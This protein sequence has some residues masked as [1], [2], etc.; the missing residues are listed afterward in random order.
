LSTQYKTTKDREKNIDQT[1]GLIEKYFAKKEPSV[2][3]H[4]VGLALD[5]ENS[6]NRSRLETTRYEFKQGL[7]RLDKDRN[8]D[9]KLITR[10]LETICGIANLGAH[11]DGYLFIGVADSEKDAKRIKEI[12]GITPVEVNKRYVVG[13]DREASI[14]KISLEDYVKRLVSKIRDSE[15]S[16]PLKTQLMG[17]F[18]TILYRNCSVVRITIPAQKDVSFVGQKAFTRMD[19]STIEVSGPQLLAVYKHFQR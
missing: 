16:E 9:D 19:S 6:L 1:K 4:G 13:I 12:D 14:K 17:K 7:L 2:L 3:G 11:S 18:D 15:L 8:E 5:F 10:I